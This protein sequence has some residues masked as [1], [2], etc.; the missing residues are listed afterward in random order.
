MRFVA[1][2]AI[3]VADRL[4]HIFL[5]GDVTMAFHAGFLGRFL[6]E[7]FEIRGVRRVAIQAIAGFDRLMFH[8]TGCERIVVADEA[9]LVPLFDQEILIRRLMRVVAAGAFALFNRLMFHFQAGH[10]ILVACETQLSR[11]Q[12]RLRRHATIAVALRA[13]AF[14]KRLMNY[15]HGT[16]REIGRWRYSAV[17]LVR[18]NGC[19]FIRD[20]IFG[21]SI[22][23]KFEPLLAVR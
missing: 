7:P 8:L 1:G 14:T 15:H 11:G 6:Q 5:F 12:F 9:K 10:E 19:R 2:H 20:R 4:M 22:E 23:E 21:H 13:F 18:R 3:P 17:L 16:S